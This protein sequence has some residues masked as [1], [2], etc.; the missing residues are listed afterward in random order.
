MGRL[1]APPMVVAVVHRCGHVESHPLPTKVNADVC[2]RVEHKLSEERCWRC[3]VA[4]A[5]AVLPPWTPHGRARA[6]QDVLINGN[7]RV[8]IRTE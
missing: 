4:E 1:W 5:W 3:L 8:D 7:A 6:P 2:Q